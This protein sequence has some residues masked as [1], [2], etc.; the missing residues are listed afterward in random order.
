MTV[1]RAPRRLVKQAIA[2]PIAPPPQ[3]T[4]RVPELIAATCVSLGFR[5]PGQRSSKAFGLDVAFAAGV[6]IL[7]SSP[8]VSTLYWRGPLTNVR[9]TPKSGHRNSAAKCPLCANSGHPGLFDQLSR[10]GEE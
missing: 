6:E 7:T 10:A 2:A 1:D 5:V 4:I 8:S 3:I 9:F